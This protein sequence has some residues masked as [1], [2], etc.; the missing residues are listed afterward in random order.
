MKGLPRAGLFLFDTAA[1]CR[2]RNRTMS[3]TCKQDQAERLGAAVR[4]RTVSITAENP[5]SDPRY[6]E[7]AAFLAFLRKEFP[8][9]SSSLGWEQLGDLALL[10]TWSPPVAANDPALLFYGHFDVVPAGDEAAWARP[11]FGGEVADG[12][13]WGRGTLD[14]KNIVM[15]LMETVE[16]LLSSSFTPARTLYLA[17]G[18]DE[19]AT[20]RHGAQVI[21]RTLAERGVRLACVF[22][23]GSII[24]DGIISFIKKPLAMIG[25][26]EKGFA[27]IEVTVTGAPGHSSMPGRGT[28]AGALSRAVA[29]IE[30][31]RFAPRLT[32]VVARFFAAIAPHAQGGIG[33]ALRL[34]KPLWFLL[35]G[36][37]TADSSVDALLR[38]TQAVTI[39]R[40]GEVPNVIPGDARAIVNVRLLP[41]DTT[42][43]V[44][45]RLEKIARRAV[46]RPFSLEVGF[47]PH[48]TLNEPV[49]SARLDPALW[50]AVAD[51]VLL[52]EPG[53]IIAPFLVLGATDSRQFVA[54]A[55]AIV[56]FMPTVLTSK[57]VARLHGVD[58]R[59]SLDNYG[60]MIAYYASVMR[61]MAGV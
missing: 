40:S 1:R 9:A 58:E 51:S 38:T 22:D 20:G 46:A 11:P 18:G 29:A 39:L 61:I 34:L 19:E 60:R 43:G 10:L 48:A 13:I 26:A 16:S 12:F 4:F 45:A 5:R 32:P 41:G 30:K 14:D 50:K 49:S 24:S 54:V 47:A 31:S 23:E 21:A 44:R 36:A 8:R 55:D 53:A 2:Y 17:F 7:F 35:R 57:D 59:I 25:L 6:A 56:R 33:I 42:A 15:A 52:V 37:L 3:I 28:A 27:N